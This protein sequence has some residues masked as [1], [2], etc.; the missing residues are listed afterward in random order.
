M[1]SPVCRLMALAIF[2]ALAF[3]KTLENEPPTNPPIE[4]RAYFEDSYKIFLRKRNAHACMMSIVFIVLFP[5]GA[6]AQ[7]LP[8]KGM[9]V[10]SRVHAPIQLLGLAMMIGAMG[11][12]ID[13]AKNDLNYFTPVKAHV[14]IGLLVTCTVIV[15]Q[16]AMGILQ[17]RQFKRTGGRSV[18]AYV[19][20]WTGRVVIC[21]GWINSGLGFQLVGIPPVKT[22]SLVRNFVIM[23][24]LG[25]AWF[26]LVGTD[27]LREHVWHK[28]RLSSYCLGWSRGFRLY[29]GAVNRDTDDRPKEQNNVGTS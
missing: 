14:A 20:R 29:D 25:G 17:H 1:I 18:F 16:P 4:K 26:L 11:L 9:R 5:L 23:G 21:L 13:I 27:G 22:H 19:H 6:I 24:V 12:G 2:T 3:A 10:T 15:V 7:H 28:N 8:L